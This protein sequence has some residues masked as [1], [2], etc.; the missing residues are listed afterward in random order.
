MTDT[1][2]KISFE[3]EIKI[4]IIKEFGYE[5]NPESVIMDLGCGSGKMV[6]ELL[7][8]G[9]KAFGCG[10]RFITQN[11]VDTASMMDKGIIR[12]IDLNN[13]HLPFDD[14]TFDFIFSH[15]VFEHVQNYEETVAE[16]ARV[17]KPNGFCIHFFASRNKL[18]E[19]HV[20]VPFASII[21]SYWYLYFWV[22]LGVRNEW[23]CHSVKE[24]SLLYYN[25]LKEETN[26][27]TRRQLKSQFGKQFRDVIFCEKLVNKYSP[28]RGKILYK[29]TKFLP[30]IPLLYSTFHT[31]VIFTKTPNKSLKS[32]NLIND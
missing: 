15:S 3:L 24:R 31:R 14:N 19:S 32:N 28:R 22:L 25:Y 20:Y 26:Y 23:V 21:Q 9:Y 30:F 4:K 29:L 27:L 12:S 10:T 16:V 17:L 5:L 11:N 7:E 18:I 1:N 13:Y 8:L 2:K 6:Q